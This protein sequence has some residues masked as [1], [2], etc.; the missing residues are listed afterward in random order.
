MISRNYLL[1]IQL[2]VQLKNNLF[3]VDLYSKLISIIVFFFIKYRKYFIKITQGTA[4]KP[5]EICTIF[6]QI[7]LGKVEVEKSATS[8]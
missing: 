4:V 1:S 7:S 5:V 6:R 3:S 8:W 2:P